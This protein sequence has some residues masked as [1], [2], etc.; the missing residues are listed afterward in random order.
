[1]NVFVLASDEWPHHGWFLL[2]PLLWIAVIALLVRFVFLRGGCW[3]FG[4]HGGPWPDRA[5]SILAERYA[6]GEIG[7]EE[8]RRRLEHLRG[9]ARA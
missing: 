2:F 7:E 6:R 1:M 5:R 4:R 8:Y 9:E 3:G